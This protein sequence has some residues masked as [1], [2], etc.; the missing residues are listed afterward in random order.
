MDFAGAFFALK[1]GYKVT[2]RDWGPENGHLILEDGVM[3]SV[4][5][6]GTKTEQVILMGY[7]MSEIDWMIIE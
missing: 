1:K 2:R 7:S 4:G 6:T 5:P 3:V